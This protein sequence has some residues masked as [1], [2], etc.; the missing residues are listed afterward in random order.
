MVSG[1]TVE[2]STN[3][4]PAM[5]QLLMAVLIVSVTALSSPRQMK[6]MLEGATAS[7]TVN[8]MVTGLGSVEAR[9]V[10]RDW[11]LLWIIRG[12]WRGN[13]ATRFLIM[14]WI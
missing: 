7:V 1:C 10:A 11:V 9:S 13:L 8:A 14:P 12:V 6:I 4:F 2:Q 3:N 5:L